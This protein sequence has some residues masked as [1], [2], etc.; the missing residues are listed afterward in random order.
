MLRAEINVTL[1]KT[2]SD[3]QGLVIKHS[4]ESLGYKGLKDVRFGKLMIIE[5]GYKDK[6]RATEE[7]GQM[8]K[9]LLA[10]PII[11]NYSFKIKEE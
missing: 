2:V 4:L 1:K 3:P 7:V 5:L 10:N 9:K 8:C 6:K 11:E